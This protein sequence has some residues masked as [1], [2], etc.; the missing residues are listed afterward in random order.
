MINSKNS[1]TIPFVRLREQLDLEKDMRERGISRFRKR[2]TD[3]K[4]RGEES[5]TNYGKTLLA[6]SIRPLAEGIQKYTEEG[7]GEK[8]VQ[9]I[10]RRLLANLEPDIASLI[11]AKSIINS[12]TI[13]RKLTSAAINV[14]SK[15]EDE[16]ALR[17]FE[18]G[19][20]EHYGIVKADL[21]K[22][23]FGYQYKRRKLRESAQKNSLEW[24]VW[25]R[26]EKVHVGYKLIELMC[27][28]TGLCDVQTVITHKRREKKLIPTAK[29]L[30][31]INNR[32]DFLEV[33]APEYF[34]TIVPPRRWEQGKAIGGGY[35]SRHIKPLSLV[36]YRKRENLQ[37]LENVEMPLVYKAVNAQQDT[38]YKINE[39]ILD[40]LEK[41]WSKNIS[42]GGLP[43]AELE[44][45]PVKPHDIDTNKEAR[46]AYRQKA[47]LVHTEN[48]RQK[49]KRL[50]FAKVVWI[51]KMFR[52]RPFYHAHTLD[53]RSRC[54][55]VTNYLNGQGVDFA[56]ALHLFGTVKR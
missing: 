45:L 52:D 6:N 43:K 28:T 24:Q 22:R 48:A 55:Q 33:L 3:H 31:W 11:T 14:A 7:K 38:P 5:F 23:S 29:T 53:F 2:L 4:Q 34:P 19:R 26:S 20:P 12:I 13:S 42:I 18:E 15:I 17:S 32:N 41:A 44:E 40:V 35:Y 21:D 49:S 37:Q 1:I 46:R 51:A 10:A 8:G 39:F 30:E 25:T 50:L 54:Y 47:V 16:I 56:K 9:P 36:K 27:T